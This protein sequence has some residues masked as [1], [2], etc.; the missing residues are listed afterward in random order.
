MS[1]FTANWRQRRRIARNQRE[2]A[3]AIGTAPSPAM[4]DEL[5]AIANRGDQIFR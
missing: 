1:T 4:R 2:I 5:L 3:R